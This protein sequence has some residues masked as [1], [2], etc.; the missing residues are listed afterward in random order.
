M[1]PKMG[2]PQISSANRKF[3]D[4]IFF[5]FADFLHFFRFADFPQM[6][7]FAGL[8]FADA[9]VAFCGLRFADPTCG[10]KI[11][12]TPHIY[13]FSPYNYKFKMLSFKF[14][15]EFWLLEQF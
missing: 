5:R 11:S 13:H 15:D 12:A 9:N 8:R 6:W 10:L 2:G 4:L 3:A 1:L 14:M 7:L